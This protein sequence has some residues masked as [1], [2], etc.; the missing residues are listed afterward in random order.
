MP[1]MWF[2]HYTNDFIVNNVSLFLACVYQYIKCI[3]KTDSYVS[4]LYVVKY[5]IVEV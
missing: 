5:Q 2:E 1:D 4:K 3:D